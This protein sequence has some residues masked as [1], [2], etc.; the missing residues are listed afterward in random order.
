M[1]ADAGHEEV[2]DDVLEGIDLPRHLVHLALELGVAF[3]QLDVFVL[4]LLS[5]S[6]LAIAAVLS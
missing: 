3:V 4:E 5:L 2:L 1:R 6:L